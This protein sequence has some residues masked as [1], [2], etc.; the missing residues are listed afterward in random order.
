[1]HLSDSIEILPLKIA[2]LN[3]LAY[4]YMQL[5][6]FVQAERTLWNSLK[7]AH[8]AGSEELLADTY[9]VFGDLSVGGWG[10]FAGRHFHRFRLSNTAGIR[11]RRD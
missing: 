2:T 5:I 4:T 3:D 1:M 8:I 7:A 10:A 11:P 6:E 9:E